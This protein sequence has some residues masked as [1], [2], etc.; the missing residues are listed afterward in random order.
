MS[1]RVLLIADNCVDAFVLCDTPRLSP[2]KPVPVVV[3]HSIYQNPGMGGNVLE[4]LKSLAPELEIAILFPNETSVKTRYVDRK[5][6]QHF[7][8]V[9]QDVKAAPLLAKHAVGC[10]ENNAHSA[11]VISDYAKGFLDADNMREIA[12]AAER[13][14]IPTFV[15]TKQILGYWSQSVTFVK[16]NRVEFEAHLA[17]NEMPWRYCRNLIVTDGGRGMDLIDPDRGTVA[18]H[19]PGVEAPAVD[20]VGCGDS[21]LAALVVHY[22]ETGDIR[23]AM[24]FS[25]KVGAVAASK[26]GVTVVKREEVS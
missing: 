25:N 6:N 22:L 12:M 19:S 18:Y 21:A 4:N 11:I 24:D 10:I 5:S 14:G 1:K 17:A 13:H 9:D 26:R 8:R 23:R 3:P 16:I 15:D 2:E 20:S 7:I